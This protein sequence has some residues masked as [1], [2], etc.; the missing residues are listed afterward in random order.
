MSDL[1]A[2]RL[3]PEALL[4]REL[5]A[6]H[7]GMLGIEG[8][9][10]HMQPMAHVTDQEGR[11]LW[12]LTKRE[13]DLFRALGQRGTAHFTITAKGQD[14]HACMR[15]QLRERMDRGR[16]EAIWNPG[17]AAWFRDKDDPELR[18]LALE[19]KDAAIWASTGSALAFAWETAKAN[20][21]DGEPDVGVHN[22]VI[23]A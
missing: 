18:M 9:G 20:L 8:S 6:V 19:L 7:A 15:G 10:Q 14:F 12:F 4:W 1:K 11:R 2:A 21:G 22:A 5:D 23:F 17:V 3:A 13:S 16:L